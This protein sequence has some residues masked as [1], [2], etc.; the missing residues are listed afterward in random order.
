MNRGLELFPKST[1]TGVIVNFEDVSNCSE[2]SCKSGCRALLLHACKLV[3]KL[4]EAFRVLI[5][6]SE[7]C[8]EGFVILKQRGFGFKESKTPFGGTTPEVREDISNAGFVFLKHQMSHTDVKLALLEESIEFGRLAIKS[9]RFADFAL[10]V[11]GKG[12]LG[13][14]LGYGLGG[15]RGRNR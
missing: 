8:K 4:S 1:T 12:R 11:I 15:L 3:L 10:F 13:Y 6:G 7:S 5:D 2:F 9:G 14:G